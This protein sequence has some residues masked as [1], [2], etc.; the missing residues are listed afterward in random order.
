MQRQGSPLSDELLKIKR[1]I[2]KAGKRKKEEGRMKEE[3][4]DAEDMREFSKVVESVSV[5]GDLV[6]IEREIEEL[7]CKTE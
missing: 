4:C 2:E 3:E 1:K 5:P 6:E 7:V